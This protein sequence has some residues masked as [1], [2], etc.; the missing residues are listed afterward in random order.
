[1]D[2]KKII[3]ENK[4]WITGELI[5]YGLET[6]TDRNDNEYISGQVV[7]KSIIDGNEQL[8][9]V[10]FYSRAITQ[11]GTPNKLFAAYLAMENKIG[12]RITIQGEIQENRFFQ[13]GSGQV[14]SYNRLA[15]RFVNDA[16]SNQEDRADFSFMGY[17]VAPIAERLDK[18]GKL[19]HH[20]IT[21][22][23]ANYS[24]EFPIYVKF[25]VKNEKAV[26]T[27]ANLYPKGVTAKVTGIYEIQTE[28][29]E[30]EEETAF[31]EPIKKV[32]TSTYKNFVIVS[33]TEPTDKSAYTHEDIVELDAAYAARGKDIE[34]A[35]RETVVSEDTAAAKRGLGR[36]LL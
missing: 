32:F 28:S 14:I 35:A 3:K 9:P 18:E 11:A 20:E 10:D 6:K 8:I 15:G 30:V 36:A 34:S 22:A 25:A 24:G 27:M 7:V 33:G 4:V 13:E 12:K 23:E 16:R 26:S 17:V 5:E 19:I 1:M 21:F 2:V 31:G 29:N